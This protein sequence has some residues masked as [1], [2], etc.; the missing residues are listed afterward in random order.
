MGGRPPKPAAIIQLEGISHRT[1]SEMNQRIDGEAALM[2][3]RRMEIWPEVKANKLARE[4][5]ERVSELL[6]VIDKDDALQEGVVNRYCLLR[7]ECVDFEKKREIF[8][9]SLAELRK[10]Y[11]VDLDIKK[12]IGKRYA[13]QDEIGTPYCFTIDNETITDKTVTVR[14]R[15][16]MS[17]ERI[18]IDKVAD[19]LREK[20]KP[21]ATAPKLKAIG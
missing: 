3:H 21:G 11:N 13:R 5:F 16:T 14:D 10:E 17:Q 19:Y 18:A 15:N 8:L 7:A 20:M 4:E 12:N 1:K 2:T 6:A 9:R